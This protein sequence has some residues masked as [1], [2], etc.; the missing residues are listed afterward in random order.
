MSS[1]FVLCPIF[2][3]SLDCPSILLF[4]LKFI[5]NLTS[6]FW[7][8][9]VAELCPQNHYCTGHKPSNILNG[10]L[11]IRKCSYHVRNKIRII[12]NQFLFNRYIELFC[13]TF[14]FL[15]R[16]EISVWHH[17][18]P[19]F[20][21]SLDCPSILLFSLKFIYNLTSI[22]WTQLRSMLVID[23]RLWWP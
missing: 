11:T 7:I 21:V 3:V 13:I 8:A 20:S 10:M 16:S 6:I 12:N 18:S 9:S 2:S 19:I 5:Y 1:F 4:S 15:Y 17:S 22:F 14:M 23:N